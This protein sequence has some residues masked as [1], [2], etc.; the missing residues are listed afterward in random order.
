MASSARTKARPRAETTRTL[1]Q[2]GLADALGVVAFLTL[3]GYL[4]SFRD[5]INLPRMAILWVG[6]AA[7]LPF[8]VRRWRRMPDHLSLAIPAAAAVFLF[9]WGL[10]SALLSGGPWGVSV[11][12]WWG[13]SDGLLTLAGVVILLL[14][15]ATLDRRGVDRVL[16]WLLAGLGAVAL[17][18]LGQ[19]LGVISWGQGVGVDATLGNPNIA[20]GLC[21]VGAVL[22]GYA[23]L[24]ARAATGLRI[25]RG[26]VAGLLVV[27]A[28]VNGSAQG[29][30]TIAFGA[31]L[32]LGFLGLGS[33]GTRRKVLLAVT[34]AGIVVAAI[35]TALAIGGS[36]PLASVWTDPNT[37]IRVAAWGAGVDAMATH[38]VFG[39]GPGGMERYFFAYVPGDYVA[40]VGP[41]V[42]V[43]ALHN[44]ALQF[45]ATLG[46]PGLVLWLVVFVG[47][48]VL[49]G[50]AAW[51]HR[52]SAPMAAALGGALIAYLVQGM[53]SID[54]VALM[55]LGWLVAGLCLAGS[56]DPDITMAARP[57]SPGD[58][59]TSVVLAMVA[60][61]VLLPQVQAIPPGGATLD[62]TSATSILRNPLTPCHIRVDI[63]GQASS[64]LPADV[65]P[66]AVYDAWRLDP[67]C[68]TMAHIAAQTAMAQGDLALAG[69]ASAQAIAQD[70]TFV[71]SWTLRARYHALNGEV[72]AALADLARAREEQA[73]YP[74]PTA[75]EAEIAELEQA[76]AAMG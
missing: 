32:G 13:R 25:A 33:H 21:A 15:A 56:R 2:F 58:V 16:L 54:M 48:A 50:L 31:L 5:P 62:A 24:D 66:P 20:A 47:A 49:L 4:A 10:L 7:L 18:G 45:G 9:A 69:E 26:V 22:L 44:I 65:G 8:V 12:G 68:L 39:T 76:I 36:G 38:P 57:A 61:L 67:R 63:A 73:L 11:Y 59:I 70:P 35:T 29:P 75:Y 37:Q 1:P 41:Q 42:P 14:A 28:V 17:I 6:A 19:W 30:A 74:D 40:L 34:G 60:A 27:V 55:A 3:V 53:V 71:T 52:I 23:A 46:I 43:N 51:R 72:D 64:Q